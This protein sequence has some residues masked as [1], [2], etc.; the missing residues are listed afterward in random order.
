MASSPQ[1][2]APA[3]SEPVAAASV[4]RPPAIV[5]AAL[6]MLP[7]GVV[8]VV[9]AVAWA[10]AM[11]RMDGSAIFGWALGVPI[12]GLCAF[13]A[14]MSFVACRDAWRGTRNML[15]VPAGL[16]FSLFGLVLVRLLVERKIEFEP[17]MV[18]PI[19][20][21]IMAGIALGLS[22]TPPAQEWFARPP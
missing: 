21:A 10:M 15:P 7:V 12:S 17:T 16:V 22:R 14:Y 11:A 8:W 1:N 6:L 9:C 5:A 13:V 20:L 3:S 18:T 4:R 2:G 19:V